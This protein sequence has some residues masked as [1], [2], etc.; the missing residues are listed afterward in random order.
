MRRNAIEALVE[1]IDANGREWT[2]TGSIPTSPNVGV[3][4]HSS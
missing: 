3:M 1:R 2:L 4:S